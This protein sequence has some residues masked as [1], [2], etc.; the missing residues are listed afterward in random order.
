MS[1][2]GS[3]S[4]S[5]RTKPL[6]DALARLES[7]LSDLAGAPI[8][9]ERPNDAA[10]GDY[11]TNAA[12]QLAPTRKRAPRELAEELA[13][14]ATGLAEVERAE[15]AGPGFVNLWLAP[16]WYGE[17]LGEMLEAGADYGAGWAEQRERVQVEMVS[18]NPTGPITVAS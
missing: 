7:Q 12:L 10:H 16:S 6:P 4:C 14:A 11:A 13:G 17:A 1:C 9:L 2:A 8:E 15:V 5:P 18:A 3:R